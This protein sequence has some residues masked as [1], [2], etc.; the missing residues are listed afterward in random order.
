[1]AEVDPDLRILS[2]YVREHFARE[3]DI[4]QELVR[5]AE[6]E[7]LPSYQISPEVGR[8]LQVLAKAVGARRILEIGTLG[9][10]SAVWLARGLPP[11]GK[12]VTI[13]ISPAH[14]AFARRWIARANLSEKID[15]R[16]GNALDILP[17]L[18]KEDPFDFVFIDADKPAYPEYLEWSLKLVRPGGMITADN[19]LASPDWNGAVTDPDT[20]DPV[21]RGIQEFNRKL[22]AESRLTSIAIPI[23]QGIA[24]AVISGDIC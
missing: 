2:G 23:R 16:E 6:K 11:D 10:Y 15:V 5:A 9:G 13:E 4:L 24:A 7:G 12:L 22:S 20:Q 21:V 3:D 19:V 8:L 17:A 18:G 14:A 1:M